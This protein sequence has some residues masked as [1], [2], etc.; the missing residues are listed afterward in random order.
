[1]PDSTAVR[2]NDLILRL[3]QLA[4]RAPSIPEAVQ[5]TLHDL[6]THTAAVGA[7]YFQADR[8]LAFHAR[9]AV[10]EM[11]QGPV[12]DAILAHGLPSDMPL[13]T[14]LRRSPEPLF[15]DDTAETEAAQG[16]AEL[17]V[18]S[19]AAAPVRD[20]EGRLVGA[21]LM[22]T[23]VPH[24]WH[25]DEATTFTAVANT[26]ASLTAR[27]VAEEQAVATREAAL[28]AL[29]L[30]LE[31]KDG[32]TAGHTDRVTSL[33]LRIG[34]LMGLDDTTLAHLRWGAYLHDVG[35]LAVPDAILLKPG[36]LD[37]QEWNV[38]RSH[39]THGQRIAVALS[40]VPQA[41]LDLV[42][43]HHERWDGRGYP[44]R[45]AGDAIP[46]LARIFA[47]V[48]VYDALTSERPYKRAWTHDEAVREIEANAGR[49]FDPVVVNAFLR[50]VTA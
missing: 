41:A 28:R 1:M 27:L 46:P 15:F 33:A 18:C 26:I 30:A 32:E 47:V 14:A 8:G 50:A 35:K 36:A 20:Q 34:H 25:P 19:L 31:F 9:S 16:F 38:M 17:G 49:Q 2:T 24:A 21:F 5:P 45:L 13:L 48:D 42:A 7:A 40:F 22:H 12:M 3:T 4:L 37:E 6:V 11:P 44:D 39:V 23:F 10:G 29:G 43:H